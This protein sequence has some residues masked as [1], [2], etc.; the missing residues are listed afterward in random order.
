MSQATETMTRLK[1][2]LINIHQNSSYIE[3]HESWDSND[4][5]FTTDLSM[6]QFVHRLISPL[7]E[8]VTGV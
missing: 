8:M 2:P 5:N 6:K 1:T 4:S 3:T 7:I